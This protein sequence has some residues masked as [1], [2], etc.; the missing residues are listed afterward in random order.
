MGLRLQRGDN[1][2][3]VEFAQRR[4][5][6][7]PLVLA[8]QRRDPAADQGDPG[9]VH[10]LRPDVR[11][12]AGAELR[13]AVVQRAPLRLAGGDDAGVRQVEGAPRRLD[14]EEL[15]AR[16]VGEGVQFEIDR[17]AAAHAVAVPAVR[18]QVALGPVVELD[19]RV[20]RVD[21][22]ALLLEVF[23][24][25][26]RQ[27]LVVPG[28]ALE[29]PRVG[30]VLELVDAAGRGVDVAVQLF[31][32]EGQRV[33]GPV[34]VALHALR[35]AGE[36]PR[37]LPHPAGE[38][39]VLHGD[40][41]LGPLGRHEVGVRLVVPP[42]VGVPVPVLAV[43]EHDLRLDA[44]PGGRVAAL[45]F[46]RQG[47][48]QG[49]VRGEEQPVPVPIDVPGDL[50]LLGV[51][52]HRGRARRG[53]EVLG[54]RVVLPLRGID[55]ELEDAR[56]DGV[57]LGVRE[58]PARRQGAGE[59]RRVGR[60]GVVGHEGVDGAGVVVEGVQLAVG[61]LAEGDDADRRRRDLLQLD[62]F[63]PLHFRGPDALRDPVAE[64][65]LADELR[66]LLAAVD[67]PAGH[68]RAFGVRDFDDGRLDRRRAEFPADV[69]RLPALDGA[70]AVVPGPL[71]LVDEFP[72]FPAH[73][74][75][76]QFARHLVEAHAPRVAEAVSP[77]LAAGRLAVDV[78]ADERVVLGD[79]VV[80]PGV[81]AVHVDAQH[82]RQQVGDVLAGLE[83]VRRVG[84]RRVA[85]RNVEHS[86][87]A[88]VQVAA[89]VTAL[90][91]GEQNLLTGR[92]DPRRFGGRHREPRH[93]R[94][95]G[96]VRLVLGLHG[97]ADE[98]LAVL[99]ELRVEHHAV[100]RF[101]RDGVRRQREVF[102][103]GGGVEA[104][105]RRG[106]GVRLHR[107]DFTPLLRHEQPPA[108]GRLGHQRRV[109]EDGLGEGVD[110]FERR[111]G[112]GGADEFRRRPR[113]ATGRPLGRDR[114]A[115]Q[116]QRDGTER[117]PRQTTTHDGTQQPLGRNDDGYRIA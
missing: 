38:H 107:E 54:G 68:A 39:R 53:E 20:G 56:R 82:A 95:V 90:Q 112:F 22:P 44:P 35:P 103:L 23:A 17:P 31:G 11:H 86:V 18:V 77:D 34:V 30:E 115:E 69:D 80:F 58:Q 57:R 93:P 12:P 41:L 108:A 40:A 106:P 27:R 78:R 81:L 4:A 102:Q 61:V 116:T 87:R 49:R 14:A 21:Q 111:R 84:V 67:V 97:V 47:L 104:Q 101:D 76:P 43:E 50:L 88:E 98:A 100:S 117:D 46:E 28:A 2:R 3:L 89:V 5:G 92:V 83:A 114:P 65:V 33:L 52:E 15:L 94:A 8:L 110:E 62:E 109:L 63:G 13:H 37:L 96:Q 19:R 10:E 71:D 105:L 74:A 16:P 9:L 32:V 91:V 36:V 45:G 1:R 72:Q 55:L 51:V 24:G 42:G 113:R 85:G 26:G 64:D 6:F 70:P 73:V 60:R 29:H 75:D 66:E 48:D 59:L 7:T 25:V 79:R 99:G